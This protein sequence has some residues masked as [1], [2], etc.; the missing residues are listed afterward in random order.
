MGNG[1]YEAKG[2]EFKIS[3]ELTGYMPKNYNTW[4]AVRDEHLRGNL[5]KPITIKR[6]SQEM[7]VEVIL[8]DI[9]SSEEIK[10]EEG[11]KKA[12]VRNVKDGEY[13]AI[14]F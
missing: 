10:K 13:I 8:I 4:E 5:I 3:P 7:D 12:L 11:R 2:L 1:Y 14:W 9:P 6:D